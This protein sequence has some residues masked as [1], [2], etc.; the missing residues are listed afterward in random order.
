MSTSPISS[1][2]SSLPIYL[3]TYISIVYVPVDP[4]EAEQGGP[5]QARR[6][7]GPGPPGQH[8]E[9]HPFSAAGR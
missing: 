4:V 2:I 8:E 9:A 5:L 3:S 6:V 1:S 7:P